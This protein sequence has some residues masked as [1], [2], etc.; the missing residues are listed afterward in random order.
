[1]KKLCVTSRGAT[2]HFDMSVSPATLSSLDGCQQT[3]VVGDLLSFLGSL[4]ASVERHLMFE[5]FDL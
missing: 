4:M 5:A 3:N 1:M 2:R